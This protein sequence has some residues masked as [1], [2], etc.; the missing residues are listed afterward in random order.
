MSPGK[1]AAGKD[2]PSQPI[3]TFG[4]GV[5]TKDI[6]A[7]KPITPV[8]V[9]NISLNNTDLRFTV[10]RVGVPVLVKVSY[11]PNWTASGAKGPYRVMP[12]FMVVI[13]TEKNVH[14]HYGFSGADK[15][16]YLASFAG[17]GMLGLLHWTRRRPLIDVPARAQRRGLVGGSTEADDDHAPDVFEVDDE[18]FDTEDDGP[19]FSEGIS[20]E[21]DLPESRSTSP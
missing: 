21:T 15:L 1:D 11:F 9:S 17:I 8:N 4:A 19:E 2:L 3:R 20:G 6:A 7:R 16:G 18:K 10:D 5:T 12:N 14:L 13:P